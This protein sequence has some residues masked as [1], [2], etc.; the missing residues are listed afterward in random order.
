MGQG[1]RPGV[2]GWLFSP[3]RSAQDMLGQ[4]IP[5]LWASISSYAKDLSRKT[6]SYRSFCVKM[7]MFCRCV[8]QY[9]SH[10]QHVG[11]EHLKCSHHD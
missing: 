2:S 5:L 8:I 7:E 11:I 4:V 9:S 6:Q 10:Y 3:P 1:A